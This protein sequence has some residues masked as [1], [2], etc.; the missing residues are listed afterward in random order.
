MSKTAFSYDSD[1]RHVERVALEVAHKVIEKSEN[2]NAEFEPLFRFLQ[3]A[4]SNINFR[5][6]FQGI[7]RVA[8]IEIQHRIIMSLHARFKVESIEI[9]YPVRKLNLPPYE[10]LLAHGIAHETDMTGSSQTNDGHPGLVR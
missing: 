9:N 7:D 1:L 10:G 2:A 6:I 8:T 3:F 4:D 5:I